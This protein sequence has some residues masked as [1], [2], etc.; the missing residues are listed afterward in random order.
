MPSLAP[1]RPQGI[2]FIFSFPMYFALDE[3]NGP[4]PA[5]GPTLLEA[6]INS[7]AAGM[8]VRLCERERVAT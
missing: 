2:Y 5:P 3:P 6:A 1:A 7:F 4:E 8:L